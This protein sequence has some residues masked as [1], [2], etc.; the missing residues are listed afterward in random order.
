VKAE[1]KLLQRAISGSKG[2][3]AAAIARAKA[4]AFATPRFQP[5]ATANALANG[6]AHVEQKRTSHISKNITTTTSCAETEGSAKG[7]IPIS[8]ELVANLARKGLV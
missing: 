5:N 4:T 6:V 7:K 3:T 8:P 1:R 2:G